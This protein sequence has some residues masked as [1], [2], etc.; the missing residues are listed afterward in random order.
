ML[1]VWLAVVLLGLMGVLIVSADDVHD[2][3]HDDESDEYWASCPLKPEWD[4]AR[5]TAHTAIKPS[6]TYCQPLV[7]AFVQW[8]RGE[9]LEVINQAEYLFEQSTF[10]RDLRRPIDVHVAALE[11]RQALGV[12]QDAFRPKLFRVIMMEALFDVADEISQA[13]TFAVIF[14]G[15]DVGSSEIKTS[16]IRGLPG[17]MID[18]E[19]RF[20]MS[21]EIV[22]KS[23]PRTSLRDC[24]GQR[25]VLQVHQSHV[26]FEAMQWL[27]DHKHL[28][29]APVLSG[30]DS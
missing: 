3:H 23:F 10:T 25:G 8:T 11:A 17:A 5:C 13:A 7:R 4:G 27:E 15:A 22:F 20:D 12:V 21:G 30:D 29:P 19:I 1:R 24:I 26:F 14:K 2:Q 18:H 28:C 6:A 9:T 16:A